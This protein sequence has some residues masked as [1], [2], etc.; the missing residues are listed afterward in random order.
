MSQ[1]PERSWLLAVPD[2]QVVAGMAPAP[3]SGG[4]SKSHR[5]RDRAFF[6]EVA[7]VVVM[8]AAGLLCPQGVVLW[9]RA[10]L[11]G[12]VGIGGFVLIGAALVTLV[13]E[14]QPERLQGKRRKP[15]LL[16]REVRDTTLAAWMA[17]CFLAWPLA[18]LWAGEQTGLVWTLAESG[19]GLR[20]FLQTG[21]ALLV[22]DAW[23][24]LKHRLLHTRLLFPFH[25]G[26][27]VFRDPTALAGFAVGPVE[28]VLT[29]W[30]LSLLAIPQA[31]HYAPLYFSLVVGF[32]W[33][34][35]YL[36]CGVSLRFLESTL[37]RLLVNTSAFHNR[38]HANAEVNFGE[39]FTIWDHVCK[40]REQ[41]RRRDG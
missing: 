12:F 36:H 40:T 24:Y 1:A 22:L 37:P 23:L 19:G 14:R 18:R 13:C 27:H 32:I 25:R 28:S 41:D 5:K 17:A 26:H 10:L 11:T 16:L 20:T 4:E 34:N 31:V 21:A 8:S 35:F 6:V 39:A 29:F 9:Y 7:A 3:G 33:L 30:P 15:P 2:A 38:H